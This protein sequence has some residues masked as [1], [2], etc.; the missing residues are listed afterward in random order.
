[1]S[2]YATQQISGQASYDNRPMTS[3][4]EVKTLEGLCEQMA[5]ALSYL[6]EGT[7]RVHQ[8]R[9]RLINPRPQ[10]VSDKAIQ[11]PP[12]PTIEGRMHGLLM[13]AQAI[14]NELNEA[15]NDLDRAA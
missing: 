10:G 8:F 3:A 9:G 7:M 2:S 4:V 1:M 15:C 13:Q 5:K 11:T 14:A 6:A 12:A